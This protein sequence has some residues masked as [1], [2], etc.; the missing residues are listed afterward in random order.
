[1]YTSRLLCVGGYYHEPG[2]LK[3]GSGEVILRK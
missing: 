2:K 3:A 1:L